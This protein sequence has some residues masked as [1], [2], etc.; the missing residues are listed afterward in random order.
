VPRDEARDAAGTRILLVDDDED[1]LLTLEAALAQRGFVVATASDGASALR[2][3]SAF[4][5]DV[6]LVDIG[7]PDMDG[8]EV[9]RRLRR[10]FARGEP[11]HL[12]A[13]TGYGHEA[14]RRRSMDAGFEQHLVKPVDLAT[15]ERVVHELQ[16]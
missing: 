4:R 12:V 5:P 15:L 2:R 16:P 9:A 6:A 1:L 13:V 10:A 11:L 14:D 8:Y 3:A 7:L